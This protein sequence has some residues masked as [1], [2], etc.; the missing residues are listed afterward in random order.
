M[1]WGTGYC[2][3]E[4][5]D[6]FVGECVQT[7]PAISFARHLQHK[8]MNGPWYIKCELTS[9][10]GRII[11]FAY[12]PLVVVSFLVPRP[13]GL[14]MNMLKRLVTCLDTLWI[15]HLRWWSNNTSLIN[16]TTYANA[17]RERE[18]DILS[19]LPPSS[20]HRAHHPLCPTPRTG[21]TVHW[22]EGQDIY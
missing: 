13:L 19:F 5:T 1:E 2:N 10:Q 3:L 16:T 6:L 4:V 14:V 8:G 11:L 17:E 9:C 18:R 20:W 12:L 15:L 21:S 22:P 7:S